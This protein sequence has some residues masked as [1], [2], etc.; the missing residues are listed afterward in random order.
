M[1]KSI[2]WMNTKRK[3]T[4]NQRNSVIYENRNAHETGFDK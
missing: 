4:K 3:Q 1:V 2:H